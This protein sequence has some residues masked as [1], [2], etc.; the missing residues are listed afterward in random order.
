M[1]PIAGRFLNNPF[2]YRRLQQYQYLLSA[3][4]WYVGI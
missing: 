1:T 3:M 2:G 4:G